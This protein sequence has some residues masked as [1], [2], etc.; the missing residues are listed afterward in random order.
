MGSRSPTLRPGP[1]PTYGASWPEVPYEA[2]TIFVYEKEPHEPGAH[3]H[4]LLAFD[5]EGNEVGRNGLGVSP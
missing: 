5:A 3:F 4:L 1:L 2:E